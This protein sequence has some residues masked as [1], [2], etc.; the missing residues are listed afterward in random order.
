MND[1]ESSQSVTVQPAP[2]T[3]KTVRTVYKVVDEMPRFM[4]CEDKKCSDEKMLAFIAERTKYPAEALEHKLEGRVFVQFVVESDGLVG[5]IEVVRS[6]GGGTSEEAVSVVKS[7]N[8]NG[9][10]WTA[11][12][13]KGEKVAVRYTLPFTFKLDS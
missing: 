6:I 9:P 7:F 13:L 12:V 4:G 5:D 2:T 3:A 8:D 10:L 1:E 11:G